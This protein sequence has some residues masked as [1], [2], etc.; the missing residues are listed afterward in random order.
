MAGKRYELLDSVRGVL[1][2]S[3]I[4]YHGTWD[5]VNLFG[6]KLSWYH[7][8][9]G[10]LWQQGTCWLFILL[11]GFCWPLGRNALK[12]GL[13]VFAG[14]AA[15]TLVTMLTMPESRVLFGVLTLIGS[16]MLLMI[17]LQKLLRHMRPVTGIVV[18]GVL[19]LF[20]RHIGEGTLGFGP[21]QP[22]VLPEQLYH[23]LPAAYL[24]FAEPGFF[25]ADYFP[26][27]PWL[28]LFICGYF[29]HRLC[30]KLGLLNRYF[31]GGVRAFSAMGRHS[32]PIY[33]A[34]QPVL[35][36]CLSF[37]TAANPG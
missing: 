28:F 12:R 15:V 7:A 4:G 25:S 26:L 22:V 18:F 21:W 1:L 31:R 16:C 27:F 9:P 10:E 35:Y 2:L 29:A 11:S 14:G 34:H 24:G 3:M 30:K 17:P 32:L 20:T 8:L 19:F 33:L 36:A 5:M 6:A 37:L 13:K 23:G